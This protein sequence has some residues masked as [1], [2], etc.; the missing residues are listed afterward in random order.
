MIKNIIFDF[1]DVFI[2]LDKNTF[3]KAPLELFKI[4]QLPN[5]LIEVH[6][7]YEMGKITTEEFIQFNLNLFPHIKENE[8]ILVWNSIL[9]NFPKHRLT[10][11]KEISKTYNCYL[12]SNTNQLHIDWIKK[13]WG[14][15]LFIEFKNCFKHLSSK[16]YLQF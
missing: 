8:I 10:F 11:I 2:N 7:L 4:K 1:G 12:L 6:Q 15:E 5:N 9:K 3:E 13:D 14:M 16:S